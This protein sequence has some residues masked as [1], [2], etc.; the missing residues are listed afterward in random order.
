M[1]YKNW[2]FFFLT[3]SLLNLNAQ[4]YPSR[5]ISL[6]SLI[7]PNTLDVGFDGRHYSGCWGWFQQTK[8]KEYA[9]CGASNGT[10][11]IDV[12]SPASPSVSAFVPGP[13]GGTFREMKT[14][15][16]YCYIVSDDSPPNTFQIVDM[17]YLPDSVHIIYN[18]TTYFERAHTVWID[19]DKMY[20]GAVLSQSNTVHSAMQVYSLATPTTPVLLRKLEQDLP[21]FNYVHD[22]YVRHDTLYASCGNDGL[23]F[24]K[25]DTLTKTFILLG[26]YAGYPYAGYSHSSSLTKNGKYL[27]F[28]DELPVGCP[29]HL[30]DVQNFSNVQPVKNFLPSINTTPHNPYVI[31]NKFAVVACYQEGLQIYNIANPSNVSFS[32]YF[33]TY[34]QG[35]SNTG[36]YGDIA[37]RGNWGAYPYLPSG[38]ILANDMQNGLFILDATVAY[39]TNIIYSV[40]IKNNVPA[41]SN[42]IM[43]PNPA[44]EVLSVHYTTHDPTH[45]QIKKRAGT[46]G[47]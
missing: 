25:F 40:G 21:Q 35:G 31:G 9:I 4:T 6:L 38:I 37:F 41:E 8:N 47:L 43:Y 46:T 17:Q 44:N 16:H 5:N 33:D 32:G 24:I 23:Q 22:M 7:S 15:L 13:P 27:V 20:L 10:Y 42:L 29:I 14:Y 34:P 26:S 39:T 19:G 3:I 1:N 18:G 45:L 12:S 28:C 30:V 2:F 11:F 36:D